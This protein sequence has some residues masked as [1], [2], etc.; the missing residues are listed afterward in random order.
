MYRLI[1]LVILT[2]LGACAQVPKQSVQLSATVGR[3]IAEIERSHRAMINLYYDQLERAINRF[4]DEVYVPFQISETLKDPEV[5]GELI[6]AMQEA[7]AAGADDQT[8]K[9]TFEAIG[10]YFLSTRANI[11]EFRESR[12]KPVR[13]QRKALL[14]RVDEAYSR[15][16]EGNSIVTGYLSSLVQV[17]DEQN[18][19][20]ASVGLPNIQTTIAENADQL[21]QR[22]DT[23][24]TKVRTG[25]EKLG[26]AV[27]DGKA[28][29]KE[30][31]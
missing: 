25:K 21:S 22:L 27:E 18:K 11:E 30:I 10:F 19:L 12:L 3:D 17:T 31:K 24:T 14:Q 16:K 29:L 20:L 26:Q 15:V 28:L 1:F 7:G 13:E 8:K 5:G 23:I 6:K 4:V 9:D 2:G